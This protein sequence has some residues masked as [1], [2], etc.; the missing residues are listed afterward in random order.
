VKGQLLREPVTNEVVVRARSGDANAFTVIYRELAPAV[1]GYL[2]AKGVPEP[3]AVTNDVFL[4]VLPRLATMTGGPAGLRTFVFSVA[5]ARVVD[6][7]R[8]RSRHPVM[9][10]YDVAEDSRSVGSA[11]VDALDA[12]STERV[13]A[14][15]AGLSADQRDVLALRVIADLTVDE[16]A[17]IIGRSAGAVK[18][19][20]RRALIVLRQRLVEQDVTL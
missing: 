18:Q 14:L 19:L 11:E 9:T 13:L 12:I 1:C 16:V 15:L 3:D 10:E 8:R 5:H 20:Q 6:E 7:A 4:A 2:R 17:N